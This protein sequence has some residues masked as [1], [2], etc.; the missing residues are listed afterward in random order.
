MDS[1]VGTLNYYDGTVVYCERIVESFVET[2]D[3]CDGDWTF[4][5]YYWILVHCDGI[6]NY[7]DGKVDYHDK[8][9]I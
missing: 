1:Y 4:S 6:V 5:H 3:H 7:C 2:E 9:E 8:N